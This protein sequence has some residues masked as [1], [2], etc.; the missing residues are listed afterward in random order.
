MDACGHT[1]RRGLWGC[2]LLFELVLVEGN[3]RE[4]KADKE[5]LTSRRER[6]EEGGGGRGFTAQMHRV[7]SVLRAFPHGDS[8][9]A[10]ADQH[11]DADSVGHYSR[12]CWSR[13]GRMLGHYVLGDWFVSDHL[14]KK[15]RSVC[16]VESCEN[17]EERKN[18]EREREEEAKREKEREG[19]S[20]E[21]KKQRSKERGEN[22]VD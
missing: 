11:V 4:E 9:D 10:V 5:E 22:E 19:R 7:S 16:L 20:K 2:E 6:R 21:A 8:K 15:L 17:E 14:L 12:V 18:Q 1:V 13:K 3:G